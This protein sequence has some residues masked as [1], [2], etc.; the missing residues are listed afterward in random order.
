MHAHMH[1][2][3]AEVR[4]AHDPVLVPCSLTSVELRCLVDAVV[5]ILVTVPKIGPSCV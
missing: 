4:S 2:S 5:S 1:S 3:I